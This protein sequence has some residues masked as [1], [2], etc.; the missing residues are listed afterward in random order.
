MSTAKYRWWGFARRMIRD[1]PSL[2]E[3]WEDLHEQSITAGG[4]G[5]GGGGGISRKT[6]QIAL[7]TLPADDQKVF[8][9]VRR[10]I[11]ITSLKTEGAKKLKLIDLMYWAR[12]PMAMSAAAYKIP[13]ADATAKR[14]HG[15][16][17]RLVG[18][19]YGFEV[20]T[21]EPK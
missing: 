9:A 21:S 12:S 11:E 8:D 6:E 7:R 4:S 13:V 18:K 1:Y 2:K 17:V 5:T 16:F 15:E 3:Q 19:S 20:D 10:A 14:W